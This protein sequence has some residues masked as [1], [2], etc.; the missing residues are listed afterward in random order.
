VSV[1]GSLDLDAVCSSP[2]SLVLEGYVDLP[3]ADS[4]CH[5]RAHVQGREAKVCRW[6]VFSAYVSTN[7]AK[8]QLNLA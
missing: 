2:P 8:Q 4:S 5:R 1:I 7:S 6:H 3:S